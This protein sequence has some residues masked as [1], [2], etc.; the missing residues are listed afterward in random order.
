MSKRIVRSYGGSNRLLDALSSVFVLEAIKPSEK[1]YIISPWIT[2]S[3]IIDNY[4]NNYSSL[5]PFSDQK[6]IY[7]SDFIELC[8][9]RGTECK[10]ITR[11]HGEST[12]RFYNNMKDIVEFRQSNI[13]HAKT[14]I[15]NNF[16]IKGSMNF[17]KSG[18]HFNGES[19][20]IS[21]DESEISESIITAQEIWGDSREI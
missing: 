10:I 14:F 21:T 12:K 19:I 8:V 17:T 2:N 7:L 6:E 18:I 20:D 9:W 5:F 15:T 13:E 16:Y 11:M 1:I 4:T 3:V